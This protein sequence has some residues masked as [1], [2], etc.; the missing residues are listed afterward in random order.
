MKDLKTLQEELDVKKWYESVKQRKDT[1][2][3][4]SY[5]AYCAIMEEYPCARASLAEEKALGK[6]APKTE[7][8]NPRQKVSAEEKKAPAKKTAEKEAP[9]EKK[10]PAKKAATKKVA[11]VAAADVK[12]T[13]PKKAPAAKKAPAKKTAKK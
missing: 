1:C 9:A 3:T 12:E 13:K 7:K 4:Y 2:G 6:T 10:T 11:E 5:C 8:T